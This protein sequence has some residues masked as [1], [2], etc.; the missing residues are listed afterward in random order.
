MTTASIYPE[1]PLLVVYLIGSL[2]CVWL[3]TRFIAG[4]LDLSS[5]LFFSVFFSDSYLSSYTGAGLFLLLKR[6]SKVVCKSLLLIVEIKISLI[7][8]SFISYK[9]SIES[10]D[11]TKPSLFSPFCEYNTL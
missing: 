4:I 5:S 1:F 10:K 2:T 6:L 9:L 7:S 11:L 3:K 8:L